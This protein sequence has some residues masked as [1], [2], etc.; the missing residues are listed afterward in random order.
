MENKFSSIF[1][2]AYAHYVK[3]KQM[4]LNL[5]NLNIKTKI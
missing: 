1:H 3:V 5:Q 4:F 2:Y